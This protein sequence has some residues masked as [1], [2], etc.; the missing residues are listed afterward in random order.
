MKIIFLFSRWS[1]DYGFVSHFIKRSVRFPPLNLALLAAIAEENGHEAK[2]ID[3]QAED[4]SCEEQADE[5]LE[6]KPDIIAMTATTPFYNYT[7]DLAAYLKK[8]SPNI[9]IVIGGHHITILREK[10]FDPCFDY[11]FIGEADL[12]LPLFLKKYANKEDLSGIKGLLYRQ[13]DKIV[14][15]GE[16]ERISNLD[17]LPMPARHLLKMENYKMGTLQ[18]YKNYTTIASVR[19]CPFNCIFC[20]CDLFGRTIRRRSPKLV[21]EEINSVIRDHGIRHFYFLDE[22]L[23]LN[24]KHVIDICNLIIQE[25]L[26]ITFEG[27]TR[28]NLLDEDL[29]K[30]MVRAGLIRMAFGLESVDENIRK[31]MKK[32]IPLESYVQVNKLMNKYNIESHNSCMIG[33]PGETMETI[34]K[35]LAFLRKSR[36]IKQANLSIAIPYPGTELYEMAKNKEYGLELLSEDFT[37]YKRYNSAVMRV[38]DFTPEDLID[39][40]N[41]AIASIYLAPWRWWPMFRKQG[42]MG[43]YITLRRLIKVILRGHPR[44]LTNKQLG[45]K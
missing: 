29:V 14:F 25:K 35:T 9:P 40:Q 2:I 21:I 18:G 13:G 41:E 24:R 20:S 19:G 42:F 32:E 28:A 30:I 44:F 33:M 45:L 17:A 7:K 16:A 36:D 22:T 34:R 5:A 43:F 27:A 38:G 11:A 39:L 26:N 8:K 37:K 15:T 31:I 6:F 10:S 4:L 3:G 12:S 1:S 23:T